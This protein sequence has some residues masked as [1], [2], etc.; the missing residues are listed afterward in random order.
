GESLPE[1]LGPSSTQTK[2]SVTKR[3]ETN[4]QSR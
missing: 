1:R 3:I 4:R 2:A